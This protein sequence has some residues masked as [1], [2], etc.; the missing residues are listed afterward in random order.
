[1]SFF[2][3]DA[4]TVPWF[5]ASGTAGV[6]PQSAALELSIAPNP[7]ASDIELR[8]GAAPGE[9]WRVEVLDPAGRG[10]ALVGRGTGTGGL[11]SLRWDG[12]DAHG[13]ATGAGVY[14][15]RLTLGGRALTRPFVRLGAR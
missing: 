4:T 6:T 3:T 2:S 1:M 7:A 10:V 13:S 11:E 8:F 15:A 12:R 9:P 5:L 14:W